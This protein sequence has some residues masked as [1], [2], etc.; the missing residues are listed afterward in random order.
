[1]HSSVLKPVLKQMCITPTSVFE[2]CILLKRELSPTYSLPPECI[3]RFVDMLEFASA[4]RSEG[5]KCSGL[6][7]R[8][9]LKVQRRRKQM[10]EVSALTASGLHFPRHSDLI[11]ATNKETALCVSMVTWHLSNDGKNKGAVEGIYF[12][13]RW[14]IFLLL[15]WNIIHFRHVI[16]LFKKLHF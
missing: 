2:Y 6:A 14:T 3:F 8:W 13:L 5:T 10:N 1:M 4:V 12:G 7:Q 15:M 16:E 11:L 9:R